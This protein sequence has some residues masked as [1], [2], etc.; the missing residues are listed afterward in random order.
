[1]W[2]LSIDM[3]RLK[4][5][6]RRPL[7]GSG[8]GDGGRSGRVRIV[9]V[10]DDLRGGTQVDLVTLQDDFFHRPPYRLLSAG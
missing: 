2:F 5:Q 1:M 10:M 4:L 6:F 3:R 7:K 9:F 8:Q